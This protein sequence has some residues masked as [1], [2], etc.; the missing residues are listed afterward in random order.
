[1]AFEWG[2]QCHK[3]RG[4]L[5]S[6]SKFAGNFI[7]FIAVLCFSI[8][9]LFSVRRN[10]L[11]E[12]HI[13]ISCCVLLAKLLA[14]VNPL[15]TSCLCLAVVSSPLKHLNAKHALYMTPPPHDVTK[16]S[17]LPIEGGGCS[18]KFFHFRKKRVKLQQSISSFSVAAITCSMIPC[19]KSCHIT[20][21]FIPV[22]TL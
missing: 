1:M 7:M 12:L 6:C 22:M 14:S 18:S 8:I 2:H 16:S 20:T 5:T 3:K 4:A 9:I 13:C 15:A 19:D 21:V 17:Q 11:W 10:F